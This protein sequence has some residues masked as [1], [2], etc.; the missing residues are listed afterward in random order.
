MSCIHPCS[1]SLEQTV[2][3][4]AEEVGIVPH[5]EGVVARVCS[6]IAADELGCTHWDVHPYSA[7]ILDSGNQLVSLVVDECMGSHMRADKLDVHHVETCGL[8]LSGCRILTTLLLSI[9]K[10]V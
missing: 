1:W 9:I 2:V 10:K 8:K 3:P 5:S 7:C 4:R 6:R